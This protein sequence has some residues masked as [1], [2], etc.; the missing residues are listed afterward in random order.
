M[1]EKSK[2]VVKRRM[3]TL[4][5]MFYERTDEDNPM[6]SDEIIEYLKENEVPANKKTLRSDIALLEDAGIDIVTVSSKP[7]RYFWGDRTFEMPELKL[8]IDAVSSSRFITQKKSREL[9]KKLAGLASRYQQRDLQRNVYATN[10]VKAGNENIYYSMDKINTAINQHRKIAFRYTEY[11]AEKEIVYRNNGEIY[12]V[13]P[14]ALFW[15]EDFYYLIGWS[16][17]RSKVTTFRVDRMATPEVLA[18][19]AVEQPDDFHL[20][21]YSRA[22]FEMYSGETVTVEIECRNDLMKYVIDRFGES[23]QTRASG[24]DKFIVTVNV[25]LSPNF[26]AWVLRFGRDMRILSP[27]RAADEMRQMLTE[28]MEGYAETGG[29]RQ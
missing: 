28:A 22:I 4:L 19:I 13:S 8:L 11:T 20:E 24:V 5:K 15:N 27:E 9:G 17:K 7:N 26:Y 2:D 21:D 16:D 10:R 6:T 23:V 1:S 14:F 18:E 29:N 12:V 3:L 25:D